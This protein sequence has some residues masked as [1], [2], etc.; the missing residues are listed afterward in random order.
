MNEAVL[1]YQNFCQWFKYV[2]EK[3]LVTDL[4][5]TQFKEEL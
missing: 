3:N 5:N 2:P 4:K 1:F